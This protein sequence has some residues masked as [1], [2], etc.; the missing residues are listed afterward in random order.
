MDEQ[1]EE[2]Y[3]EGLSVASSDWDTKT[4]VDKTRP[5]KGNIQRVAKRMGVITL[6]G[7][8]LFDR[9]RELSVDPLRFL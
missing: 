8:W 7:G 1:D 6:Y 3:D 4:L 5:N 2:I 9:A